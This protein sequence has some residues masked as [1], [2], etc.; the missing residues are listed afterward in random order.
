MKRYD[1]LILM[2]AMNIILIVGSGISLIDNMW[3]IAIGRFIYGFGSNGF[4]VY[5]PNY[6][7]E[8]V[9]IELKGPF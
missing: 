7:N 4:T 9:P 3:V 5:A 6:T 2:I 1:K 8:V